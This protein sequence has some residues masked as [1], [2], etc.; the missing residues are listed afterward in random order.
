MKVS[1]FAIALAGA[2]PMAAMSASLTNSNID[3]RTTTN[4]LSFSDLAFDNLDKQRTDV[5]Q[6]HGSVGDAGKFTIDGPFGKNVAVSVTPGSGM[7]V[8]N[9]AFD[10][11]TASISYQAAITGKTNQTITQ[12]WNVRTSSSMKTG[13][14]SNGLHYLEFTGTNNGFLKAGGVFDYSVTLTGDWSTQGT[15]TGDSQLLGLNPEFTIAKDFVFD[16]A[17]DTT[18][19]EV[20]NSRYDLA[21]PDV[22]LDFIVYGTPAVSEPLP[23]A[24]LLAGLGALGW[25]SRRRQAR[26]A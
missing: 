23:S 13:V 21:H 3:T 12:S 8:T 19:L 7:K 2:L 4:V 14:A 22:G 6:F 9:E 20:I 17:S 25:M 18:T 26:Q 10:P 15:A 1:S 5:L 24:L 16:A 11:T